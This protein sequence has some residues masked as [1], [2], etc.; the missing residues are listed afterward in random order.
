MPATQKT[1]RAKHPGGVQVRASQRP[2][3]GRPAV[4]SDTMAQS[5]QGNATQGNNPGKCMVPLSDGVTPAWAGA[6]TRI[7]NKRKRVPSP[8]SPGD[9]SAID[10]DELPLG[11]QASGGVC[12]NHEI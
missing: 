4:G 8:S 3:R 12:D 2:K 1:N 7:S 5:T 6:A 9:D 10:E 11:G